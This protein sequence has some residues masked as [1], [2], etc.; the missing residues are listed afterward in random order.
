MNILYPSCAPPLW[1]N[2]CADLRPMILW[3][4]L[5][6]MLRGAPYGILIGRGMGALFEP[7]EHPGTPFEPAHARPDCV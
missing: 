5:E 1:A 6:Y 2:T 3:T 7:L 4:L